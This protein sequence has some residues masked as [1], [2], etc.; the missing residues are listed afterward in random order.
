MSL[1]N[2]TKVVWY[3]FVQLIEDKWQTASAFCHL[4]FLEP[5]TYLFPHHFPEI[6]NCDV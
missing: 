3:I 2:V 1:K 4:L 6:I 5:E